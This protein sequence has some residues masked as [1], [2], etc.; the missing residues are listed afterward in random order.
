MLGSLV[1]FFGVTKD[2]VASVSVDPARSEQLTL[3]G[4]TDFSKISF[5]VETTGGV[6][7][8]VNADRCGGNFSAASVEAAGEVLMYVETPDEELKARV[9]AEMNERPSIM[10]YFPLQA[11]DYITLKDRVARRAEGQGDAAGVATIETAISTLELAEHLQP[12][13]SAQLSE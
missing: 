5:T 7:V 12:L 2:T 6:K 13:L 9:E 11:A 1:T 4:Y 10:A 8:G 3:G